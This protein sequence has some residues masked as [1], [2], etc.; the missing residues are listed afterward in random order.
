MTANH[1]AQA[2]PDGLS[3]QGGEANY[4]S[5]I[6]NVASGDVWDVNT[7]EGLDLWHLL[8]LLDALGLQRPEE[9]WL[10]RSRD[11]AATQLTL[12]RSFLNVPVSK[13]LALQQASGSG[14]VGETILLIAH[15]V[16]EAHLGYFRPEDGAVMIQALSAI[17]LED[18]ARNF[19]RELI[20]GQLERHYQA[21]EN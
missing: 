8:P 11:E 2:L 10:A 1:P 18:A 17:G 12:G 3:G 21:Q 7:L 16:Q 14:R 4:L 9:E 19:G 13:M 20:I 15:L 5:K 6:L